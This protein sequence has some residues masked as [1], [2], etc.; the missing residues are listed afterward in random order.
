MPKQFPKLCLK[1]GNHPISAVGISHCGS[2][3]STAGAHTAGR[4]T[5]LWATPKT[6]GHSETSQSHVA[7]GYQKAKLL[8]LSK[9]TI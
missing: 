9:V 6:W 7:H 1:E 2:H 8:C 4:E 3:P 5:L